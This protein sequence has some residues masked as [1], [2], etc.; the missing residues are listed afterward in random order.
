MNIDAKEVMMEIEIE[1]ELHQSPLRPTSDHSSSSNLAAI[2][3][4]QVDAAQPMRPKVMA[5]HNGCSCCSLQEDLIAQVA[6]HAKSSNPSFDYIVIENSGI[7]QPVP[8][9]RCFISEGSELHE[10]CRLDTMVTVADASL[11]LA[12]LCS[13]VKVQDSYMKHQ[14]LDADHGLINE[15][16]EEP[17]ELED[18]DDPTHA[19]NRPISE[20]FVTQLECADVVVLT[21]RD[22]L[23]DN[24]A[25]NQVQFLIRTLNDRAKVL[26]ADHGQVT[27]VVTECK[28]GN[29]GVGT[30][31]AASHDV[32]ILPHILDT[33][34][35]NIGNQTAAAWEEEL[36]GTST[37]PKELERFGIDSVIFRSRKPFHPKKLKDLVEGKIGTVNLMES[38]SKGAVDSLSTV[39]RSKG[40]VWIANCSGFAVNWHSVGPHFELTQSMP[41]QSSLKEVGADVLV[42]GHD[43]SMN[44]P[45]K[46]VEDP[47]WGS[48]ST[49]LVLIGA[50]NWSVQDKQALQKALQSALLS[51]EEFGESSSFPLSLCAHPLCT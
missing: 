8:V 41:F 19:H 30:N 37:V 23:P 17:H 44:D 33:H 29:Q 7:S 11:M 16:Q 27:E 1:E 51:D 31:A 45:S 40:Q 2:Q 26:W 35:F 36:D 24:Q 32:S 4:T 14:L 43:S 48:R 15:E 18:C 49:E 39:I 50:S 9:A 28:V 20:L 12:T 47:I 21:K 5:L 6:A 10:L 42:Q 38:P 13:S 25:A 3:T 22:L 46:F 34:L